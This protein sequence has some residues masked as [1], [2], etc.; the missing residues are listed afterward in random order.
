MK[1]GL[2]GSNRR[3]VFLAVRYVLRTAATPDGSI[4]T[5]DTAAR[6][7]RWVLRDKQGA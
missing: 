6:A 7:P 3:N 2:P 1:K 4:T 5:A